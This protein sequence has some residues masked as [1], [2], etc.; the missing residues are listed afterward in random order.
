MRS[1]QESKRVPKQTKAK[2]R[3]GKLTPMMQQYMGVKEQY[4]DAM[5]FFRMGDFFEMFFEDAILASEVMGITQTYRNKHEGEPIPMAGVPHHSYRNYVNKMVEAGYTVVICDQVEDAKM[6][7]GLVKR[8]VT[9]IVTPGMVLDPDDLDSR[10]NHYLVAVFFAKKKSGIA[11][12]DL[13]TGEFRVTELEADEVLPETLRIGPREVLLSADQAGSPLVDA[14]TA[15]LDQVSVK[16]IDGGRFAYQE[17]F[18]LLCDHFD[19]HSLDGF[20]LEDAKAIVRA[21]GAI[22]SYVRE[23]QKTDELPHIN[24][25]TPYKLSHCMIVDEVTRSNLE[26]V[27]NLKD[28]SRKGSLF[29]MLDRSVTAMGGRKLRQWLLYPLM[30]PERIE[31]RLDAVELFYDNTFLRE[32]LRQTLK[33]I[34]DIERLNG[35]VASHTATPKDLATLRF[36]L[37]AVPTLIGQLDQSGVDLTRVKS[38]QQQLFPLTE[39]TDDIAAVLIDEAP[40]QTKDGGII[41]QGYHEEL[42]EL[43]DIAANGKDRIL[44]MQAQEQ[45]ATGIQSLKIKFNR[46]FGYYIEVTKPNVQAGLVPDHYIRK[47]TMVNHERFITDDLKD[48][49]EKI[50]SAEEDSLQLEQTLFAELRARVAAFSSKISALADTIATLD[51]LLTF[52]ELA[53]QHDYCRPTIS[54]GVDLHIEGGRHPVIEQ[55]LRAGE[56]VPNDLHMPQEETRFVLLTGPN[57]SGKSTC[58]RQVALLA[59]MAQMGSFVPATSATVG[60]CDRIFTRV[61][62]SDNLAGGQSTF[63]VEMTETSNILH[64]ATARSLVILDEIG[65]GTSTFDGISI[66]WAVAEHLHNNICCRTLFATHYHELTELDRSLGHFRNMS[67]SIR[68][69]NNELHFLHKL[70]DGGSNRSYGIQVGRLAGLPRPVVRRAQ[71]I[72]KELEQ[73]KL[74]NAGEMGGVRNEKQLSLFV[75]VSTIEEQE[76]SV[77]EEEIRQLDLNQLSPMEALKMLHEWQQ[78]LNAQESAVDDEG[79]TERPETYGSEAKADA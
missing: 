36:S 5:L 28:R 3:Q 44:Q 42:D 47:Q 23:T 4:P 7:K 37:E 32:E 56:F 66:A 27:E 21:A 49:E 6:A 72:L 13:T 34:K 78:E 76:D 43:R 57:M 9:R 40:S 33:G 22:L 16:T 54:D 61:G 71:R 17:S 8:D 41:R 15:G 39:V 14:F 19:T 38:L 20:G 2:G 53:V 59:L 26:L 65:R 52:A 68:E 79:I 60:I 70:V 55:M 25:I 58:M 18:S 48:F 1:R 10:T 77:I 45:E 62:A 11:H 35:K 67:I 12:I 30:S 31:R 75:P 69:I 64:N 24:K 74:P 63:M 73:G 50:I 29:S 51:V 46:V